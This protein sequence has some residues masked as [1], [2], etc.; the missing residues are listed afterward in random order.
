MSYLRT[1]LLMGFAIVLSACATGVAPPGAQGMGKIKTPE[2]RL[3]VKQGVLEV[4]N[5]ETDGCPGNPAARKGCVVTEKDDISFVKFVLQGSGQYDLRTLFICPGEDKP[6]NPEAPDCTLSDEQRGEFLVV[7]GGV[8]ASPDAKGQA[9]LGD[10]DEF[11]L[12][13]QNT[14]VG[15]YYY[16]I[17]ACT[18]KNDCVPMDP[19]LRNGGRTITR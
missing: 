15:D 6:A 12:L 1:A 17:V 14:F 11:F 2:I 18:G 5:D 8:P 13:N 4:V 10:V 9:P 19:R 3:Q 16:L 7:S